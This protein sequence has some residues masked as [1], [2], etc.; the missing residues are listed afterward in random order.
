MHNENRQEKYYSL[1]KWSINDVKNRGQKLEYIQ[2]ILVSIPLITA[3][4]N[5]ML[6]QL[7]CIIFF[8]FVFPSSLVRNRIRFGME[9]F[10]CVLGSVVYE[11][12]I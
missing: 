4:F 10:W 3:L 8:L 11:K 9:A 2:H 12:W 6:T 5:Y 1:N 7:S